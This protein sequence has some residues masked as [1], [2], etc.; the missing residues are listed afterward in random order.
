MDL[1]WLKRVRDSRALRLTPEGRAGLLDRF[2]FDLDNPVPPRAAAGIA[3]GTSAV[4]L[5]R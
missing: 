4:S 3:A 2:G 5:R 1:G